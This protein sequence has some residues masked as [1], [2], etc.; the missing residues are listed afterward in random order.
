[1][2]K[3]IKCSYLPHVQ[4]E[5]TQTGMSQLGQAVGA[6]K[7]AQDLDNFVTQNKSAVVYPPPKPMFEQLERAHDKLV[8]C[9]HLKLY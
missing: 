7:S 6:I 4:V 2:V 9:L 5:Q 3:L 8:S 1:M